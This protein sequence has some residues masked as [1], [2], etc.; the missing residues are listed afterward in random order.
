INDLSRF[1]C[2]KTRGG[3]AFLVKY[4]WDSSDMGIKFVLCS[5]KPKK[6][7]QEKRRILFD[8]TQ[9]KLSTMS[10]VDLAHQDVLQFVDLKRKISFSGLLIPLTV[11]EYSTLPEVMF[12]LSKNN[13]T[14]SQST[15]CTILANEQKDTLDC[16]FI[17]PVELSAGRYMLSL[18][19]TGEIENASLMATV[20]TY[21]SLEQKIK[22]DDA[23]VKGVLGMRVYKSKKRRSFTHLLD[24]LKDSYTTHE[25][26]PGMV[27]VE[28][29]QVTGSAYYLTSMEGAPNAEYG[30]VK[31]VDYDEISMHFEYIGNQ[32]GWVVIPVR[33]YPGW[34]ARVN[35]KQVEPKLF[36]GVMPAIQVDGKSVIKFDYRPTQY[37]LPGLGSLMGLLLL[38][39]MMFNTQIVNQWLSR[40][41]R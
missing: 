31:L 29:S 3:Q 5:N 17:S 34:S 37:I 11:V 1:H 38:I 33:S 27:L 26:E 36:K 20:Q 35:D 40:Y 21:G 6:S 23:V 24:G 8:T 41:S 18:I 14:I 32:S 19:R 9:E 10:A 22:I 4:L 2:I 12:R 30:Q 16:R 15:P 28:N 13:I 25:P 39:V 7:V